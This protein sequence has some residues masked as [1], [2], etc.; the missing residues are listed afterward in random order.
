MW[1]CGDGDAAD[2]C[3]AGGGSVIAGEDAHGGGLA[4][5]VWA[6]EADDLP[7]LYLEADA[8]DGVE[9]AEAFVELVDFYGMLW[10]V[11]WVGLVGCV[12]KWDIE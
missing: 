10:G 2:F 1:V 4:R 11:Q 8:V 3:D 5:S 6:E 7:F 12:P 9:F